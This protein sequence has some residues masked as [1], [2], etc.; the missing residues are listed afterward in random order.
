[1]IGL[2]FLNFYHYKLALGDYHKGRPQSGGRGFVQCE[3]F[4]DSMGERVLQ[5]RMFALFAAKSSV[6][7]EIYVVSARTKEKGV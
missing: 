3:H 6:F 1:M 2:Y 7:F 4:A 5:M